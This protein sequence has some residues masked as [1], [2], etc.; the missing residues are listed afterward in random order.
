MDPQIA[1]AN[2][3]TSPPPGVVCTPFNA[4]AATPG[5]NGTTSPSSAPKTAPPSG[6]TFT[7]F[8]ADNTSAPTAAAPNPTQP[9]GSTAG[10]MQT[11]LETAPLTQVGEGLMQGGA[12]TIAGL[13][14]IL[15][16]PRATGPG[17]ILPADD[18][19]KA[20][21]RSAAEWLNAH[22]QDDDTW[23]KIGDFGE[24][25][26]ELMTPEALGSLAKG[27]EAVKAGTALAKTGELATKAEQ[28]ADAAKAAKV[29]DQYPRIKALVMIGARAAAKGA[30]E[31]G[32]QTY[33]KTGGDTDAATRAAAEGAVAGG[34]G[35]PLL[36][37]VGGVVSRA[38]AKRATTM[39]D[40]GGVPTPVSAETRNARG[41]PQQIAGRQSI[42]NAAQR[43]SAERLGEVNESRAVPENAP[44]L[45][46]RTGPFEFNLK[47]P[48]TEIR[49]EGDLL[50]PA[51]K[52][53]QAAFKQ[54]HYLTG[55]RDIPTTAGTEGTFGADVATGRTP[56]PRTDVTTGG[57]TLRTQDPN[58]AKEHI[59]RLN[60]VIDS[61]E[62]E[63]MPQ[64]QQDAVRAARADAQ[65]QMG[66]YHDEARQ[67]LPGYGKPNLEQINIPETV[68]SIG[69]YTEAANHLEG[70]AT[71]GYNSISDSL[72]LNDISG[73]KF[74][75]IRN[76]NKEAWAKYTGATTPAAERA[77]ELDIDAINRQMHDLL[78]ND[79]G[80]AVSAK[81]LAGFNDAY[82][83]AQKLKYVA[84]AV[85]GAFTGNSSSAARSW[86]YRGFNGQQLMGN[87]GKLEQKFGRAGLERVVGRENLNTLYQ[88]AELNRTN[89]ARA[90]FGAAVTPV[91][92][93]L[94]MHATPAA[95]GAVIGART[96]IGWEAGAAG[97]LALSYGSKQAMNAIVTNPK[98]AQ[99]L[100]FAIE[101]GAKPENYGPF[102]GA[103][104][105]QD[106]T[107]RSNAEKKAVTP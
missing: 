19:I 70:I 99:N 45:P 62:F 74:N 105:Q 79:I 38:I 75:T 10:P 81:E 3:P 58:I 89:A 94:S 5:A 1:T 78:N 41:T 55:A 16:T 104:I 97:G 83:Q 92:K 39:E 106:E 51:A 84:K 40:V 24:S 103:L 59:A 98:I 50:H 88:V 29:L 61:P 23:Q 25:A 63:R 53:P 4:N 35:A 44:G 6:V 96:G 65:Q 93:Y 42:K 37:G 82:G 47:G 72:A 9:A 102:I 56:E 71:D 20:H 80:G 15:G 26:L 91:A 107:E 100:I 2:A 48:D 95:I 64:E 85:D 31:V 57:G 87:L 34:I 7:P 68:K 67:R 28:L 11:A 12:H 14:N 17:T 22:S 52:K 8:K 18:P 86:E 13:L 33:V 21:L 77:A 54:P 69:S 32:G 27:T 49:T 73:G 66:R 30:A 46:A 101:S 76:A 43:T 60:D 36:E 90:R